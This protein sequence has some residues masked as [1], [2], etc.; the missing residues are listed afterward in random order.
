MGAVI[1]YSVDDVK[2]FDNVEKWLAQVKDHA[3]QNCAV[4]LVANK[5][6]LPEN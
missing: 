6:D 2:S 4:I 3:E 5:C 1:A